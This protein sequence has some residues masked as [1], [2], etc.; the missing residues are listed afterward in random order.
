MHIHATGYTNEFVTVETDSTPS[1]L[2]CLFQNHQNT[3]EKKCS[4]EYSLCNQE[5]VL[6]TAENSTLE[7]PNQVTLQIPS[8]SDCY[9]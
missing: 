8:G 9:T 6:S 7:F 4:V 2:T 5:E 1:T 3:V